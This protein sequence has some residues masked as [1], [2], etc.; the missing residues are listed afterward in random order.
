MSDSPVLQPDSDSTEQEPEI[1]FGGRWIPA[2]MAWK[3]ME[4]AN[5]VVEHI[6]AFNQNYPHLATSTT[7]KI[8]PEVR[9]RLRNFQLRVPKTQELTPLEQV[10][11]ELLETMSPEEVIE[12]I[13]QQ[14]G[15]SLNLVSLLTLV[16]EKSYATALCREAA[17]YASNRILP[18]QTA[19]LFN[20]MGRPA[21]GGGLWSKRKI[22]R[23]LNDPIVE[24]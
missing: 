17:E 20:E 16:G 18:D 6:D 22:E 14:R 10:A 5:F 12:Q 7:R 15:E 23:L 21:P 24:D 8:V 3:K 11:R 4:S 13:A 1:R 19:Q 2:H 9:E